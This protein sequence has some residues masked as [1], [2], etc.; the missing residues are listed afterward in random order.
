MALFQL[1]ISIYV[2]Y[3]SELETTP[4]HRETARIDTKYDNKAIRTIIVRGHRPRTIETVP[5]CDNEAG[6]VNMAS[7][8]TSTTSSQ[9][10]AVAAEE[11][12]RTVDEAFLNKMK[13]LVERLRLEN[14]TL[15]KSLDIERSEVRALKARNESTLRNLKTEH[16]KKEEFL[17]KQ[18]RTPRTDKP[19]D[20]V[21]INENKL[22]ELKK[23]TIEIQS[24]KS[25]NKGLQEKLKVNTA[26]YSIL[27]LLNL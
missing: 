5:N 3:I 23:L 11:H 9:I 6:D 10:S 2:F 21:Q 4:R 19:S 27:F 15:K 24:L 8:D 7:T 12:K 25:A 18:L 1:C 22:I 26:N 17:E 14:A 16:R 20:N 13:G